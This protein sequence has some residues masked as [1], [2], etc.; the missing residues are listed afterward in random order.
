MFLTSDDAIKNPDWDG[1]PASADVPDAPPEPTTADEFNT[2]NKGRDS[3]LDPS[4]NGVSQ[5]PLD[6]AFDGTEAPANGR[7]G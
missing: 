5:D 4:Q 7:E 6:W 3:D 2:R 1:T